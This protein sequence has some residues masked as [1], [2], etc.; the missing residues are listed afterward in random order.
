MGTRATLARVAHTAVDDARNEGHRRQMPTGQRD[1][2][3]GLDKLSVGMVLPTPR[4]QHKRPAVVVAAAHL[5]LTVFCGALEETLFAAVSRPVRIIAKTFETYG[6]LTDAV[7]TEQV[8]FAWLPPFAAS[9]AW[10]LKRVVPVAVPVRGRHAWYST[11]LFSA[12]GSQFRT[13]ADLQQARAAWVDP[14]SMGGYVVMLSWLKSQHIDPNKAFASQEFLG[15]HREVVAAVLDGRADV[16]ATFAHTD[17]DDNTVV[18][19][20]WGDADVQVIATVGRI[21]SDVLAAAPGMDGDYVE[22]VRKALTGDMN[23]TLRGAALALFEADHFVDSDNTAI[24][25]LAE[26]L[27]HWE[28]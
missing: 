20:G 18:S 7:S 12:S 4:P 15:G 9:R 13:V 5:K 16:G 28:T 26:T 27:A 6:Q 25:A 14:K 19:A 21:P 22:A 24:A 1:R 11:A 23:E 10:I 8:D 17:A 3:S 2:P